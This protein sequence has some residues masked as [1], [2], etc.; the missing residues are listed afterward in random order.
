MYEEKTAITH[1]NDG[2]V[3]LGFRFYRGENRTGQWKLKTAIP[4]VKIE[5]VKEKIRSE[6]DNSRAFWEP[7]AV[8]SRLNAVLGDGAIT[9]IVYPH[10]GHFGL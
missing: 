5:A 1:V 4:E 2:F 9:T 8:V 6:T 7:A 3:F 10:Q